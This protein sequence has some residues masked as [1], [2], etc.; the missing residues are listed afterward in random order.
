MLEGLL[1]GSGVQVPRLN[2]ST[3]I[4]PEVVFSGRVVIAISAN[5]GSELE[6]PVLDLWCLTGVQSVCLVV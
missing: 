4:A 5:G 6:V 1:L 2:A 3:G